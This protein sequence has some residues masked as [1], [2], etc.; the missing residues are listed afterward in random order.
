RDVFAAHAAELARR[1]VKERKKRLIEAAD[2]LESRC[3]GDLGHREPRFVDELLGEMDAARLG[4]RKR[5]SAQMLA[6]EAPQLPLADSEPVS[7][8]L[9]AGLV[10]GAEFDQRK[11]ARHRV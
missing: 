5:R 9:D 3:E 6:E 11:R 10:Q 7:Q 8:I 2:A 4:D 1:A